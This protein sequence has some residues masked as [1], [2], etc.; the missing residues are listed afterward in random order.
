MPSP[1]AESFQS[2][3]PPGLGSSGTIVLSSSCC[4]LFID[5]TALDLLGKLDPEFSTQTGIQVLPPCL[6]TLAREIAATLSAI[7]SGP[8]SSLVRVS[9]LLGSR[10]Q[11]LRVQGFPVPC[12]QRQ[13]IR[14]VLV[15]SQCDQDAMV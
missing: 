14:I 11:S 9:R 3:R 15:L 7:E 13:D 1:A 10:S 5:R 8:N 6:L 4:L 12:Q 2:N